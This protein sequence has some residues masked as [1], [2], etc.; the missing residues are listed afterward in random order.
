MTSTESQSKIL[1]E[2]AYKSKDVS[3]FKMRLGNFFGVSIED[4]KK[5]IGI[6]EGK[7]ILENSKIVEKIYKVA[8]SRYKL[9]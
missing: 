5:I 3:I 8:K 9:Y 7:S 6:D 1:D 4:V 2:L